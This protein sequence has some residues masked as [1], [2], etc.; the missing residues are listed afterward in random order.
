[1]KWAI[2]A[3]SCALLLVTG[4]SSL[5]SRG[6]SAEDFSLTPEEEAFS[7]AL[8]HYAQ[9][10]VFE[11][12]E[13]PR[14][15]AVLDSFR[16]AA[17][18][19]PGNH[20]LHSSV[21][22]AL[23]QQNDF[24]GA[25]AEL[26]RSARL[27]PDDVTVFVDLAR[28]AALAEKPELAS[29]AYTQAERISEHDARIY[30][31]HV[32]MLFQ[33]QRDAEAI[34][35]LDRAYEHHPGERVGPFVL[36]WAALFTEH[37]TPAR[38]VPCLKLAIEHSEREDVLAKLYHL[39]GASYEQMKQEEEA[40][41]AYSQALI[42]DPTQAASAVRKALLDAGTDAKGAADAL[43]Q[44]RLKNPDDVPLLIALASILVD[45]E[46]LRAALPHL[47]HAFELL[48]ARKNPSISEEFYVFYGGLLE[49]TGDTESSER[50][51]RAGLGEHD[52]AHIIMNYLAYTWAEAGIRLDEA[53]DLVLRALKYDPENAAYLDTLGWVYFRQTRFPEALDYLSR[54]ARLIND[55]P[56]V[57]D[58][59]GDALRALDRTPEAI[60]YWSRS[61]TLDPKQEQVGRKLREQGVDPETLPK[62]T[63]PLPTPGVPVEDEVPDAGQR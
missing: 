42:H 57:L 41:Q 6:S 21:A 3:S 13:G 29:K 1:M 40:R 63:T 49:Q 55:D 50:V 43:E 7:K 38:A 54:A 60:A 14:S 53:E 15:D 5:R 4:C 25:V 46:Q 10:L 28:T 62:P 61:Y 11:S 18:L 36:R 39:L 9:G 26:Q 12:A 22:L 34:E 58:H 30:F 24:E 33:A 16:K 32:T 17:D 48:Q 56:V 27:N 59:I 2:L 8:A 37:K 23:L 44:E 19:D 20:R 51:L 35:V 47:T 52:D 31:S 45:R